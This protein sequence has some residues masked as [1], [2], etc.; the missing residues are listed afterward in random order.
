ML[1]EPSL[2]LAPKVIER[3]AGEFLNLREQGLSVLLVEQQP[4]LA[5]SVAD[6]VIVIERGEVMRA[7]DGAEARR[8]GVVDLLTPSE[9]EAR[10]ETE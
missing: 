2:G 10:T 5:I 7:V 3:L 6:T 4:E 9:S 8:I 1:D